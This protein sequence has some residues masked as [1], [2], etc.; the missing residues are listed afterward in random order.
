[1]PYMNTQLSAETFLALGNPSRLQIV[2]WL[3]YPVAHFPNQRDGDLIKDGVCAGA[4]V[5]KLGV[6][7]PSATAHMQTLTN[8]Q[9][10]CAKRIKQWTLYQL[11]RDTLSQAQDKIAQ[12]IAPHDTE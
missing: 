1:M 2:E 3:R 9:I 11:N 10:V 12:L 8:A 5:A 7:Q 6:S 4:I